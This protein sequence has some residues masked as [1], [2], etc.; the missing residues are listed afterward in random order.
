V[1]QLKALTASS[2]VQTATDTAGKGN[3]IN[4][5]IKII[6]ESLVMLKAV[7]LYSFSYSL[8]EDIPQTPSCKVIF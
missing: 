2:E 3:V 5:N 8:P 6:N 1:Y 4:I 7:P